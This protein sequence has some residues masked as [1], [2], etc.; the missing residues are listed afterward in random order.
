[1]SASGVSQPPPLT[2][3]LSTHT[4]AASSPRTPEPE[5]PLMP[6]SW[7]SNW[8]KYQI[9]FRVLFFQHLNI[10]LLGPITSVME[11]FKVDPISFRILPSSIPC[12]LVVEV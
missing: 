3:A 8:L 10:S 7:S 5:G 11:K 1:M 4:S 12:T 2:L 9:K 6:S